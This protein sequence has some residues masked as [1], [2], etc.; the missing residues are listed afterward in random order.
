VLGICTHVAVT[1]TRS[2]RD[3]SKFSGVKALGGLVALAAAVVLAPGASA[4]APTQP[5]PYAPLDQPGPA[6]S[7]PLTQLKAALHCEASVTNA[8]VEPVLLNPATGVTP[9]ENYSWN[10]E[11][12]LDKLGMVHLR[13]AARDARQHRDLGRVPRVRDPNHVRDGGTADRGDG[14]QPGWDVDALAA[15][16]LA[17]HTQARR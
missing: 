7:V 1:R 8:K 10:W 15:A 6:L 4:A 16:V 14:S 17:G 5:P 13:S 11:P 12:A 3:V 9:A 2:P